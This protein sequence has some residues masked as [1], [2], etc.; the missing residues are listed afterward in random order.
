MNSQLTFVMVW[1]YVCQCISYYTNSSTVYFT[2]LVINLG[3]SSLT[4]EMI[5][6]FSFLKGMFYFLL[7]FTM[8]ATFWLFT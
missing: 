8:H 5:S 6:I 1:L 2:V 7:A 3:Y 4:V